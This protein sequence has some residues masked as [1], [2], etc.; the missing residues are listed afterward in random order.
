[1]SAGYGTRLADGGHHIFDPHT[2]ESAERLAQVAVLA[3][4]AVWAD[5][6]STAIYVAGEAGA[7]AL[8]AAYPGASAILTRK[9]GS[10]AEV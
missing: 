4:K 3:D 8:L 10:V 9:D 2:G 7:G 6:L 1:V 5:A